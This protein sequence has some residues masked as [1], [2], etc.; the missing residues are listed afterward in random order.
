MFLSMKLVERFEFVKTGGDLTRA[1]M[2]S[3]CDY[4]M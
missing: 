4:K 1:A 2:V 3:N